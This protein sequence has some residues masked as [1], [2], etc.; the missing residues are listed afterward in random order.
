[1]LAFL[2]PRAKDMFENSRKVEPGEW[3][4]VLLPILVVVGFILFLMW[5]I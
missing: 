2:I 3:Q 1:M 4:G 5:V